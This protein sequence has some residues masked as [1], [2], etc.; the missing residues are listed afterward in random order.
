MKIL[1][2][3]PA[4]RFPLGVSTG[5]LV[6]KIIH[7]VRQTSKVAQPGRVLPVR[8]VRVLVVEDN[9][10]VRRGICSLLSGD[11]TLEVVCET[12]DGNEAI[13]KA[14]ELL[15]DLVLL[16]IR[17]HGISGIEAARQIRRV[18]PESRIIFL[19]QFDSIQIAKEAMQTGAHGY[20]VKSD[21]GQD[22]LRGIR[23]VQRGEPFVS[24]RLVAK[25]WAETEG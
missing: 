13:A 14:Q 10:F 15:P 8:S 1:P 3:M 9:A 17:L 18:A 2:E 24:Q 22:L 6:S 23:A 7:P 16:D 19:S 25:G 12:A 20:I 5:F 11:G 21:A 4:L